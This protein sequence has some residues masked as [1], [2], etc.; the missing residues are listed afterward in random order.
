MPPPSDNM[1]PSFN[2]RARRMSGPSALLRPT[3]ALS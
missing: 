3:A 2:K 1:M